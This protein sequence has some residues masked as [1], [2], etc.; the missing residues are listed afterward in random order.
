MTEAAVVG[1]VEQPLRS[2]VETNEHHQVTRGASLDGK[3]PSLSATD[4]SSD[5][6]GGAEG[7]AHRLCR[8]DDDPLL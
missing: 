7:L 1:N 8:E 3:G 4:S 6:R 2:V 5:S